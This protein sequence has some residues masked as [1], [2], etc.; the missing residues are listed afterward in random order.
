MTFFACEIPLGFK[1]ILMEK[2]YRVWDD[3]DGILFTYMIVC[4][5]MPKMCYNNTLAF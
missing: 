5:P 1:G 4:T 3:S 2:P